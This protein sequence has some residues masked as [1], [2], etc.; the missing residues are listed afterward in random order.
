MKNNIDKKL[1]PIKTLSYI[2]IHKVA[3]RSVV[4]LFGCSVVRSVVYNFY[5]EIQIIK[6]SKTLIILIIWI[7]EIFSKAWKESQW[8]KY[9]Q[10]IK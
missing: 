6:K 8:E 7:I 10:T 1:W 4:R 5:F 9:N 3:F 2:Y